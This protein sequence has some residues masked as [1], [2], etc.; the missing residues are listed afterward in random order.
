[1]LLKIIRTG[2][3]KLRMRP[4]ILE[5]CLSPSLGGLELYVSRTIKW[6]TDNHEPPL[7]CVSES[8]KLA[9]L[10]E[11]NNIPYDLARVSFRPLPL[12]AAWRLGR[13]VSKQSVDIIHVHW[14]RDLILCVLAKSFC[15][16][17]VKVVFTRHM[18]VMGSKHDS[19][20]KFVYGRID[21]QIVSTKV[22]QQ[23][24]EQWIPILPE[25]NYLLNLGSPELD[26]SAKIDCAKFRSEMRLSTT[27]FIVGMVGRI[28]HEKGQYVVVNAVNKLKQRGLDAH[29]VVI[30]HAMDQSYLDNLQMDVDQMGI[31]ANIH[32]FGF[33]SNPPSIMRC[34]DV[35]VLATRRET[36]GLVLIEAMRAGTAVIG[37]N[38]GGVPEII[39]H[40]VSGLT[41]KPMDPQALADCL[42]VLI[43]DPDLKKKYAHEGQ[44]RAINLFSE[45][46]HYKKLLDTFRELASS[47]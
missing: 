16:H 10:F 39:E 33:H 21:L 32:F 2:N 20:H 11:Q 44:Q 34:F 14:V 4:N 19:Y 22:M 41:Y 7:V 6:L 35:L 30:G 38:D 26:Q 24:S 47:Y 31:N 27:D 17:P 13:Y 36:F 46:K 29:V 40:G 15:R 28:E 45:E 18:D 23:R 37:T 9:T 8:S 43:K 1:M 42:A 5:I 3:K 12:L 25:K